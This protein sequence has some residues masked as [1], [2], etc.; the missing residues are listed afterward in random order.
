[1][2]KL[3]NEEIES[4]ATQLVI[5]YEK[6]QGRDQFIKKTK[7]CG[8]DLCSKNNQEIRYI[9]IKSTKQKSLRGRWIEK[10]GREHMRSNQDFWVYA[11]VECKEDGSGRI[12]PISPDQLKTVEIVEEVKYVMKFPKE[13]FRTQ[14]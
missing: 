1:M 6:Q 7:G 3:R 14:T 9:E 12:I 4:I 13:I 2:K 11:V 5:A 10:M 8:W